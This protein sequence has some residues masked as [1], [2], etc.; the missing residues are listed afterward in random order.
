ME[1]RNGAGI[2]PK[3]G[4]G[5]MEQRKMGICHP[6]PLKIGFG[7]GL[8]IPNK[9]FRLSPSS[10]GLNSFPHL[11]GN[12]SVGIKAAGILCRDYFKLSLQ[13]TPSLD[14]SPLEAPGGEFK[15]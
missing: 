11:P 15:A 6:E 13:I 7:A 10:K 5:I 4:T 14:F 1:A 12:L 8:G 2:S 3:G 9:S